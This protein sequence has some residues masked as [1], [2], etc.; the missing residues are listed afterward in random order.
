MHKRETFAIIANSTM[1]HAY[2]IKISK[3]KV[4]KLCSVY[5]SGTFLEGIIN[6][7][8][9]DC[10]EFFLYNRQTGVKFKSNSSL[11]SGCTC[12]DFQEV[13]TI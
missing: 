2:Y 1:I 6:D 13:K 11:L 4:L 3:N 10:D 8:I 7:V 12:S 9:E 5:L